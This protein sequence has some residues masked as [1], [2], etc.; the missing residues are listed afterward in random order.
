MRSARRAGILLERPL[1]LPERHQRRHLLARGVEHVG[2]V[3]AVGAVKDLLAGDG[4][5]E[6]AGK[7]R[8]GQRALVR[9]GIGADDAPFAVEGIA[10]A[11][12]ADGNT[13]S[14]ARSCG[15][16]ASRSVAVGPSP[17]ISTVS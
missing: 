12:R 11:G 6:P 14:P 16:S 15:R 4:G 2:S 8:A 10:L 3:L 5:V 9:A 13:S 7:A 1:G 17:A